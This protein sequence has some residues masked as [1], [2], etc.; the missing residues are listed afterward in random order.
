MH[1]DEF[2]FLP[3]QFVSFAWFGIDET[4]GFLLRVVV[5]RVGEPEP[6][7]CRVHAFERC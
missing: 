4:K 6:S 3:V 1:S 2:A 7:S 5:Y